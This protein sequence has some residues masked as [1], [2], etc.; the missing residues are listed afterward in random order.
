MVIYLFLSISIDLH[1]L[2]DEAVGRQKQDPRV[3]QLA[4]LHATTDG[5]SNYLSLDWVSDPAAWCIA[6]PDILAYQIPAMFVMEDFSMCHNTVV[7][8]VFYFGH[9]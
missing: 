3:L 5:L 2:Y 6:I 8:N 4:E 9:A 1:F 7:Y